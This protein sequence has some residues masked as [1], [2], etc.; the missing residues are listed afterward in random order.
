MSFM[1]RSVAV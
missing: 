1:S